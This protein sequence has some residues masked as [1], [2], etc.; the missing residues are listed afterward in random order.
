M[1]LIIPFMALSFFLLIWKSP[2]SSESGR[3]RFADVVLFD[4]FFWESTGQSPSLL[5]RSPVSARV[6]KDGE[7]RCPCRVFMTPSP[8][9][10]PVLPQT[11]VFVTCTSLTTHRARSQSVLCKACQEESRRLGAER[12]NFVYFLL[13]ILILIFVGMPGLIFRSS[14]LSFLLSTATSMK[15]KKNVFFPEKL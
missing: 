15:K 3:R 1:G 8:T 10:K 2:V 13:E 12:G 6:W 9:S 5:Q 7:W 14:S 11:C 4:K